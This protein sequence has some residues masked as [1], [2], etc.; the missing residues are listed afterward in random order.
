[1]DLAEE[2]RAP[3]TV[4]GHIVQQEQARRAAIARGEPDPFAAEE[5]DEEPSDEGEPNA[6]VRFED[7]MSTDWEFGPYY[8]EEPQGPAPGRWKKVGGQPPTARLRPLGPRR[9]RSATGRGGARR[10]RCAGW[11]SSARS[12]PICLA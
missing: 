9:R 3:L 7:W 5:T 10:R 12:S 1:M 6:L 8:W 2:P 4:M 11:S